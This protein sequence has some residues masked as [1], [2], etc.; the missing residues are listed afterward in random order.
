MFARF[1]AARA[2]RRAALVHEIL[3]SIANFPLQ[4]PMQIAADI[5]QPPG[6]VVAVL[7]N[8]AQQGIVVIDKVPTYSAPGEF[9]SF[10]YRY[11]LAPV[12]KEP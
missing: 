5:N 3:T 9:S 1:R 10:R 11:S 7:R 12:R 8:L 4:T 2:H 6:R